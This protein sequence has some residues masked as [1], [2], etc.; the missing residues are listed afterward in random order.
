MCILISMTYL[1]TIEKELQGLADE[2][3]YLFSA[4]DLHILMPELSDAA[5]KSLLHR[6]CK[7]G[8][9][10]RVLKGLF[11]YPHAQFSKGD[12][13]FHAAAKLRNSHFNYVSLETALSREGVISQIPLQWISLMSSGRSNR[14]ICK[15]YG[16]IEFVHTKRKPS[17]LL[18]HLTYDSKLKLWV[19]D[20][21]LALED[22]KNTHRSMEDYESI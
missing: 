9:L 4:A 3:N 20:T 19:A 14:I 13:L 16:T 7:N 15:G 17:Q 12:L 5:F 6:L 8:Y 18:Q 11:L 10:N 1:R 2:N 22:M 21:H